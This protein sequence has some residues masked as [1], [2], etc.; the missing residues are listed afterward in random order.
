MTRH[1][2]TRE[3]IVGIYVNIYREFGAEKAEEWFKGYIGGKR[4]AFEF[5]HNGN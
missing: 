4:K 2:E 5:E 1:L 3:R